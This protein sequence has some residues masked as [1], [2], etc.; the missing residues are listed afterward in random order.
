MT[1]KSFGLYVIICIV[2]FALF[3]PSFF[4]RIKYE[5]ANMGVVLSLDYARLR[6][7]VSDENMAVLLEDAKKTG[8]SAVSIASFND[9]SELLKDFS[10]ALFTDAKLLGEN[11][12]IKIKELSENGRLKY[13]SLQN[14]ITDEKIL[15]ELIKICKKN[16][17]TL[18]FKETKDQL[19]NEGGRSLF[20]K[21]EI[22]NLMRCYDTAYSKNEK[23]NASLRSH[24]MQNSLKDRN[25]HFIN[26]VPFEDSKADFNENYYAMLESVDLFASDIERLGYSLEKENFGFEGYKINRS[27]NLMLAFLLS[28]VLCRIIYEMLFGRAGGFV[29]ITTVILFVLGVILAYIK[30]YLSA[31]AYPLLLCIS[32]SSFMLA[33][34][35][36]CAK[37]YS[38][39]GFI[40]CLCL[41]FLIA[42]VTAFLR[43]YS[44]CA[45][46]SGIDYHMYFNTFRGVKI[47]LIIPLGFSA[48]AFYKLYGFERINIRKSINAKTVLCFLFVLAIG[49][50][51]AYLFILRSG[52]SSISAIETDFRNFVDKLM[53]IRPRTKEFLIGW[54]SLAL[55]VWYV[56]KAKF[57]LIPFILSFGVAIL[58]GSVLNSFCHVFTPAMFI[59]LRTINGF[60]LSLPLCIAVIIINSLFLKLLKKLYK[61]FIDK[62]RKTCF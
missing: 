55:F 30:P 4:S 18:V 35:F 49:I 16:K 54:P 60:L 8:I 39:E 5:K 29:N 59:Y 27:L 9:E 61:M 14:E 47:S 32:S 20:E 44:L 48:F 12:I 26:L 57:R 62:K 21:G 11:D 2:I 37:K 13:I 51:G 46:L 52:N 28:T 34:I 1:K 15:N 31:M 6:D 25:T 45:L 22:P 33:M 36:Y 41:S 3:S 23:I 24:Q 19:S 56:S 58:A 42:L 40:K 10:L 43:G 7:N 53:G 17:L 50:F 38:K